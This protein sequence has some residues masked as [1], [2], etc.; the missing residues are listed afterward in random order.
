MN[1]LLQAIISTIKKL[2]GSLP[3]QSSPQT[4]TVKPAANPNA[5]SEAPVRAAVIEETKLKEAPA[6]PVTAEPVIK[7]DL[8][9]PTIPASNITTDNLPQDSIQR[10]HAISHLH[11]II[12]ALKGPRPSDSIQSRHYD[13]LINSLVTQALTDKVALENLHNSYE[14][15]PKTVVQVKVTPPTTQIT[16]IEIETDIIIAAPPT[17]SI[18]RRHYDTLINNEI[19]RLLEEQ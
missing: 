1:K 5:V 8:K 18:L 10:R 4:L 3:E 15:L 17:D 7:A 16:P 11:T 6:T 9:T 13:A 2:Y 14:S 12:E 19:N